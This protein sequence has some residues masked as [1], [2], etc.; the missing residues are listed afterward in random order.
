MFIAT[1]GQEEREGL[2]QVRRK[3]SIIFVNDDSSLSH[4]NPNPFCEG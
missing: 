2:G 1:S 4:C 3:M